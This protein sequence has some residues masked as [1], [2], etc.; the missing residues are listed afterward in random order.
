MD[1]EIKKTLLKSQK[2]GFELCVKAIKKMSA[3]TESKDIHNA[4]EVLILCLE[5]IKNSIYGD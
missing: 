5:D 3:S 2:D 4:Y 1:E